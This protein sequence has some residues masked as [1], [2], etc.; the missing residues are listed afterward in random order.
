MDTKTRIP[1]IA[2]AAMPPGVE[3]TAQDSSW[4][5]RLAVNRF[6]RREPEANCERIAASS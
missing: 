2:E 5:D 6:R 4:L 1:L 3:K